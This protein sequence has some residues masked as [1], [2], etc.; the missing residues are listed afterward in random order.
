M[1]KFIIIALVL[2]GACLSLQ[3]Q[4]ACDPANVSVTI[5]N[6]DGSLMNGARFVVYE[7]QVDA[8]DQAQPG[9]QL[10]AGTTDK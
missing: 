4:A 6:A 10:V 2:V 9:K 5:K 8:N 7:Q 3:A 1:K